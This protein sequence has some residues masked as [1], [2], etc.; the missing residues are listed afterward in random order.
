MRR[1]PA[2]FSFLFCLTFPSLALAH[3]G[4]G[5]G[6]AIFG[7]FANILAIF[8]FISLGLYYLSKNT[9]LQVIGIILIAIN[10]CL[11]LAG[12]LVCLGTYSPRTELEAYLGYSFLYVLFI[13]THVIVFTTKG[14]KNIHRQNGKN[15]WRELAEEWENKAA[16]SG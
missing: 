2:I 1:W 5:L 3:G 14:R 15:K 4:A 9:T 11:Y 8:S 6:G 13:L 10:Y 12:L 7:I 16:H